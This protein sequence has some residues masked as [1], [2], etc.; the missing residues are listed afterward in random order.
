M[1]PALLTI[2]A[3]LLMPAAAGAAPTL[4]A[5]KPCYVSV[6]V[7]EETGNTISESVDVVGAGFTP[8]SEVGLL[9]DGNT[10]GRA[11]A[12]AGGA[13]KAS[14]QSPLQEK[15]ER[16]FTVTAT[17]QAQG[18]IV[19]TTRVTALSVT[20]SP[21][22]AKP[23]QRVTIS[24]RGFTMPGAAYAHYTRG[25]RDRRTVR[26]ATPKGPCGTFKVRRRQFPMRRPATGLWIL[27]VDQDKRFRVTPKTA[28]VDLEI[29]V[30][31]VLRRRG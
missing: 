13:I 17:D 19:L 2:A 7:D 23:T 3:L 1:K 24:G 22:K 20:V 28:F 27:R 10:A 21:T 26:L 18:S 4:Q 14:V 25:N 9:V 8:N 15:G 12:D 5:L 29:F 31:S 6:G 16:D 11:V 30:K